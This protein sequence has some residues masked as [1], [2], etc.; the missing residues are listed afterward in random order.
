MYLIVN[1]LPYKL[2]TLKENMII[3]GLWFGESKPNI[4][5]VYLKPIITELIVLE[6]HGVEVKPPTFSSSFIAKVIV[7]AG[8]CDLPAKCLILNCMQYNG[9][10]GCSKCLNPGITFHTSSHGHTHVYPY[11]G[12][13]PSGHGPKRS[14][15]AHCLDAAKALKDDTVEN[16]VKG[17]SWFMKLTHYDIIWGTT[18][19]YMHCLLLGVMKLLMSLWFGTAHNSKR[20]YIGRKIGLVDKRLTEIN[21]PSIITRKPH[22]LSKHFKYFKASEYRSFLLYYS[23]PVLSDI[24][25]QEYW[26]H[27]ALLVISIH[28]L[29]QE[30]ISEDQLLCCEQMIKKFCSQFEDLY[31]R[32]YMTA[33]MHYL[34]H[35]TDCVKE[36]GPLWVYSCFH[37]ES[38][39]GVPKSLIHG[40]QKVEKQI[41]TSFSYQKNLPV[42]AEELISETNM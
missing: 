40:T 24:L 3:A 4:M 12:E 10:Y 42:A 5:N 6:N 33:N 38:Q 22:K 1:E 34:L 30:S 11:Q 32:R 17:P 41:I 28:N 25:P 2:R 7:L 14:K 35:L 16:G 26:N 37:F 9:N 15:E 20:Y 21:P 8:T 36:L 31:G 18:V 13:D 27:Y 23:L 39:N 19:D 29:L